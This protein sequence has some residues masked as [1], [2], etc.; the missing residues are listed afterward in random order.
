MYLRERASKHESERGAEA[1][2]ET[3]SADRR[4]QCRQIPGP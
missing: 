4:A 2:G 1:Q 3:D